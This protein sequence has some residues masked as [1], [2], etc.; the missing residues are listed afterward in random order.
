LRRGVGFL[1]VDVG[2]IFEYC[3]TKRTIFRVDVGD[4]IIRYRSLEPEVINPSF[5]RH[6]LQMSL[7]F[8]FRF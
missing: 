2:G 8:G 4:T 6:N 7:G 3:P 5:T 1:T